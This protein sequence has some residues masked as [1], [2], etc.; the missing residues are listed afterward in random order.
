MNPTTID[1]APAADGLAVASRAFAAAAA[2]LV[3]EGEP[4]LVQFEA[5][6]N[7]AF[8]D[9]ASNVALQLAKRARSAPMQP[10]RHCANC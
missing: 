1:G 5:P 6:R 9:Y 4:V 7:P 2:S 3:P 8:G 10:S